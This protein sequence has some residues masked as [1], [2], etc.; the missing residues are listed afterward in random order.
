M[1]HDAFTSIPH[2]CDITVLRGAE[3]APSATPD[4]LL[5]MPH[6]ATREAHYDALAEELHGPF[7]ASLKD[8]FFVNTDVGSGELGQRLAERVVAASPTRTVA[9]IRCLIPRTFV[10]CNRVIGPDAEPTDGVT[11]GLADYVRDP[12]DRERL[13]R[14]HAAYT[15]TVR[16]AFDE[17]CGR[18][19]R[20]LMLHTYAPRSVEV[21]VD[22]NIVRSLHRAYESD[23]VET[24][25]LRPEVDLITKDGDGT[26]LSNPSMMR[27][28]QDAFAA[29]GLPVVQ[30][31]AYYLHP[32]TS[33]AEIAARHPGRTLCLEIRRDLLVREF[34]PFAEMEIVEEKVDRIAR[35]LEQVVRSTSAAAA[36][37]GAA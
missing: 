32:A 24:W 30:D 36:S 35:I 15:A 26:L 18:A 17:V 2:V 27:A 6:G 29:A 25:P 3:A 5:E 1:H 7:P 14:R 33:A 13:L 4:L 16:R 19:G 37:A 11:P 9:T 12:R 34:T 20:G 21:K 28:A 8:F 22:E 10:D 23:R 31:E